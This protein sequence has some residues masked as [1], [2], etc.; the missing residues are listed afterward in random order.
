MTA[1]TLPPYD[2]PTVDVERLE[3]AE[4]LPALGPD[5][6]PLIVAS[7]VAIHPW[8]APP[9]RAA[10]R[11]VVLQGATYQV[12]AADG[13]AVFSLRDEARADEVRQFA[14]GARRWSDAQA[15]TVLADAVAIHEVADD[16]RS[17]ETDACAIGTL[18][19]LPVLGWSLDEKLAL[20]ERLCWGMSSVHAAGLVHGA[21]RP[22]D[23][24]FDDDLAPRIAGIGLV[25]IHAA[26]GGDTENV[27]GYGAFAAPEVRTGDR[28]TVRSDVYSIGQILYFALLE[29]IPLVE[30]TSLRPLHEMSHAPAGLVRIVRRCTCADPLRRYAS[31]LELL[32]ELRRYGRWDSVGLAHPD[33]RDENLTGLMREPGQPTSRRD[34]GNAATSNDKTEASTS[35]AP[36][37]RPAI[38]P[39]DPTRVRS[40]LSRWIAGGAAA[41]LALTILSLWFSPSRFARRYAARANLSADDVG[42]RAEAV[43]SVVASG[44]R[45]FAGY[46]FPGANLSHLDLADGRL[47]G[48]NL[49]GATLLGTNLSAASMEGTNLTGAHLE[50][51]TLA[52]VDATGIIGLDAAHCDEATQL[53]EPWTCEDG[54][55]VSGTR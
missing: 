4:T 55:P 10:K 18:A 33:A 16:G 30:G 41:A 6:L 3:T 22:C 26:V 47:D 24:W 34:G 53:P 49:A 27:F 17:F 1:Q 52:G 5:D 8:S 42:V 46:A 13:V 37:A 28:P 44:D 11:E 39:A 15:R 31:T 21:L 45:N 40:G 25:D 32:A 9:V 50:N 51:A 2:R 38:L 36:S 35:D 54:R 23:V 43:R 29:Q 20:I 48:T 7:G 12:F 19:D 14:E